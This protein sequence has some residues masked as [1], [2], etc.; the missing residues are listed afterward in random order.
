MSEI[1]ET[2]AN[3]KEAADY[4]AKNP[5]MAEYKYTLRCS[6]NRNPTSF[7]LKRADGD[8]WHSNFIILSDEFGSRLYEIW[9][10]KEAYRGAGYESPSGMLSI[11]GM[12][13]RLGE[14]ELVSEIGKARAAY[15][16]IQAKRQRNH[17]RRAIKELCDKLASY[18]EKNEEA[19]FAIGITPTNLRLSEA[20]L[21]RLEEES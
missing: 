15:N 20:I 19:C 4:L 12:L 13:R 6:P 3:A 11:Q 7:T 21:E 5:A 18:G 2:F 14:D 10:R 9:S 1:T 17:T 8:S 16:K